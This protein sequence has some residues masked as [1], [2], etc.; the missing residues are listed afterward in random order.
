MEIIAAAPGEEF[1]QISSA[2]IIERVKENP[3]LSL[4]TP[5]GS[6]PISTYQRL[7]QDARTGNFNF[8]DATIF[9]LDEYTDLPKYPEGSF[10]SFLRTHLGDLVFNN[11]TTFHALEPDPD[12]SQCSQYDSLLKSVGG[13]DLA[14][15][16]VGRNGHIGFNEPGTSPQSNTHIIELSADTL[17]ANFKGTHSSLRPRHAITIGMADLIA[18]K[19]VLMLVAGDKRQVVNQLLQETVNPEVP[20]TYLHGHPD[21]TLVVEQ[22]LLY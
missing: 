9:M 12:P 8:H 6:T 19:S 21:F 16:G 2:Y 18:A 5:T 14:I 22:T 10:Q 15:V 3:T 4:T 17:E 7:R 20:A 1:A 11:R 13:L